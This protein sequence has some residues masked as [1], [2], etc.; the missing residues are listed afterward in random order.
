MGPMSKMGDWKYL[1]GLVIAGCFA[2]FTLIRSHFNRMMSQ[3][4]FQYFPMAI[5]AAVAI[6]YFRR[7]E[8][9]PTEP[10]PH[11]LAYGLM[12]LVGGVLF[13]SIALGLVLVGWISF[14]LFLLCCVFL[15]FGWQATKAALPIALILLIIKPLPNGLEERLTIY[16]QQL[17]SFLGG[18]LLDLIGIIHFRQGV[19]LVLP[20]T[21]F[22][23]EE[24]CSGIR[25]LFS[26]ITA[27]VIWGV[28]LRHHWF[29]HI[30][31]VGQTI[32]WVIVVNAIRIALVILVEDKTDFSIATGMP[33][34]I[35][36]IVGFFVIFGLVL[37][38]DS[39]ISGIVLPRER[40]SLEDTPP[41]VGSPIFSGGRSIQYSF[42]MMT[43]LFMLGCF[44]VRVGYMQ[45][46]TLG[47]SIAMLP[48]ERT[49]LE[50][51]VQGWR[52]DLFEHLH[53]E[54]QSIQGSDSYVWRLEKNGMKL[55][56][57]IDG[58]F[59]DFHDLEW[60]YR[61]LGWNCF[62]TRE[63]QTLLAA[64]NS[65]ENQP[66]DELCVLESTKPTGERA[67]VLFS[68]LDRYG[69]NVLPSPKLG[70]DTLLLMRER[71]I[72]AIRFSVGM[73][74]SYSVRRSMFEQPVSTIQLAYTSNQKP[75]DSEIAE[76]RRLF[77]D[78]RERLRVS[79]RF[80]R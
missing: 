61:A 66:S 62:E 5:V 64:E 45:S 60:C 8:I 63:Y 41:V 9:F 37:S 65:A 7:G 40:D 46:D 79:K 67:F 19:V 14:V 39:L 59:I 50:D 49:D 1:L 80:A 6:A 21:S 35:A 52:I 42:A 73:G 36:G 72:S 55:T 4:H 12:L 10:K 32:G 11:R 20:N 58:T 15:G 69:K 56:L 24:A 38:T 16:L 48:S 34:Q 43:L 33:H 70:E 44:A 54:E 76:M 74:T 31:N 2:H 47:K 57:S 28:V 71:I 68:G 3:E 25:S 17:A 13:L 22:L 29:R 18:Q 77:L 53:R 75:S 26:S 27:V 23:A 78:A 51:G 30:L